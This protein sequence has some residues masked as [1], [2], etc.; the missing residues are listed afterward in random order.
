MIQKKMSTL[1]NH[2]ITFYDS[3][4]P[5]A[6]VYFVLHSIILQLKIEM[7]LSLLFYFRVRVC[8][9][10]FRCSCPKSLFFFKMLFI[11]FLVVNVFSLTFTLDSCFWAFMIFI[12][13]PFQSA[14]Q[15]FGF[16]ALVN[17]HIAMCWP[18]F[19][20]IIILIGKN[21]VQRL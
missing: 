6:F 12:A 21:V 1:C 20:W 17:G 2:H 10:S 16:D 5:N 11:I 18:M 3:V 19:H 9:L 15:I 14:P 4:Y 7:L 8:A 13:L